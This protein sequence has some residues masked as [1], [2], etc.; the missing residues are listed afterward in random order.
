MHKHGQSAEPIE[1]EKSA[2]PQPGVMD[3]GRET[4]QGIGVMK[5][6]REYVAT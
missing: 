5:A 6:V 1:E 2:A 3:L 4:V